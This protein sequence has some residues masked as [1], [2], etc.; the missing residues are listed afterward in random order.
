M[1]KITALVLAL[2]IICLSVCSCGGLSGYEKTNSYG[3]GASILAS[4]RSTEGRNYGYVEMC[5][6]NFGKVVFLLDLTTAPKT[7]TNFVGLVKGGFY[8]APL[9]ENEDEYHG[10]TFHIVE[11]GRL[12]QGGC[13]NA[14]GTGTL[15]NQ[16]FGEFTDNGWDNDI[17][18]KKGVISMVREN[19]NNTAACQ[20]FI[21]MK[22]MPEL[23]SQYA[24]FG[25]VIE[26]MS[27]LEDVEEYYSQFADPEIA[28]I[29]EEKAN[30]PVIKYIKAIPS[31]E[32][33]IWQAK[34][35]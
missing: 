3:T 21:C 6:E 14:D 7:V 29:I 1:K 9:S 10:N 22:D 33:A 23:D 2:V 34:H 13:P 16:I 15:Q 8:D 35:K 25:Y 28:Y 19:G 31:A 26:G 12:L 30:Q 18:H 11:K 20:F 24:A 27:V 5:I 32:N 4:E 17:S